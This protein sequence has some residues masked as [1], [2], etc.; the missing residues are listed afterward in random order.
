MNKPY[1]VCIKVAGNKN[2]NIGNV[3]LCKHFPETADGHGHKEILIFPVV[4]GRVTQHVDRYEHELV[5]GILLGGFFQER[6]GAF[7]GSAKQ[8]T[9]KNERAT[10]QVLY[11]RIIDIDGRVAVLDEL[12]EPFDQ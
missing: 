5:E 6:E 10:D 3:F 1:H 9:D 8:S 7:I 2:V 11:S 12:V 4:I